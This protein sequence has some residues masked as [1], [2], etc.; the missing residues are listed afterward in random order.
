[1]SI[2]RSDQQVALNDLLVES[3]KTADH[4][5]DSADF[6][7]GLE[8]SEALRNI[9]DQRDRL[10]ERLR[11]AIRSHGDL[12]SAPDEDRESVEKLF[13]R[14]HASLSQDEIRDILQ[15]RLDGEKH[16]ET[17][18]QKDREA[19]W[20]KGIEDVVDD[21][22]QHVESTKRQVQNLLQSYPL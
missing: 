8:V 17:I 21:I 20:M 19:G 10:A 3:E 2:F 5:R 22:Q 9:A 16:F 14:V 6:L 4:Y 1:M 13:H 15:Q 7:E 12:P 11:E 18:I